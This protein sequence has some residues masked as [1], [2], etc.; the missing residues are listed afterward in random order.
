MSAFPKFGSDIPGAEPSWYQGMPSPYYHE[1]HAA[2]RAKVRHLGEE[3]VK[4]HVETYLKQGAYPPEL[5]EKVST[6]Q[7]RIAK[8]RSLTLPLSFT[9]PAWAASSTP[10]SG[11]APGPTTGT[12]STS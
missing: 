2:F 8:G 11:A 1:G 6:Q 12:T 9:Q 10:R 7:R 5:H 3:E 4:P